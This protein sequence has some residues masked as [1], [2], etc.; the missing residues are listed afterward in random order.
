MGNRLLFSLDQVSRIRAMLIQAGCRESR[1]LILYLGI[2]A[3]I[4]L[5]GFGAVLLVTGLNSPLL[6]VGVTALSFSMT[7]FILKRIIR[8]PRSAIRLGFIDALDLTALCIDA[9]LA[10][11]QTM[12]HAAEDLRHRHPELRDELYLVCRDMYA[13]YTWDEA[14]CAP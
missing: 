2:R 4:T 8:D 14:L 3:V 1:H 12:K 5:L 13:G 9:G 10:P 11:L 6:L 7:R